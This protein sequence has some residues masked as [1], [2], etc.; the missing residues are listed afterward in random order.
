MNRL[1]I[2]VENLKKTY[3]G[4]PQPALDGISFSVRENERVGIIGANGSGKTTL[5]R[6]IINLVHPE[7]GFVKIIGSTDLENSK[8][9]FGFVPEHQ[10]GLEN[11]TPGELLTLAGEMYGLKRD[12][13]GEKSKQLLI[14]VAL[15][16][17][18]DNLVAGFSKGMMQRL[19]VALALIHDPPILLLDEPMSGLD[20][21]GQKMLRGLL[22]DLDNRTLLYASH[23][24]AEVEDI[25]DRII[26]LHQGKMMS[27][28]PVE[29]DTEAIIT[30]E[31]GQS[32]D[33]VLTA[34]PEIKVRDQ[35][36]KNLTFV[37]EIQASASQFQDFLAVCKEKN[38]PVLRFRSR[39]ML[40]DIYEKFVKSGG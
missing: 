10:Q 5:F 20:P 14:W 29:M 24:L 2:E 17:Q 11:F 23:N 19:Q 34:F 25:C 13:I 1:M 33:K 16:D 7:S 6:S 36:R 27:D 18:K 9:Y 8:Q 12:R 39:S 3:A 32:L 31:A 28:R 26:I 4:Q 22:K 40:E 37:Y 38:L 30:L 35:H 21:L 15:R